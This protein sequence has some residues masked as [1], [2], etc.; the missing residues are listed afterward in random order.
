MFIFSKRVRL[1]RRE[2]RFP[3]CKKLIVLG[4]LYFTMF[5]KKLLLFLCIKRERI[6]IKNFKYKTVKFRWAVDQV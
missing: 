4:V 6:V 3:F 1:K 2:K 5:L